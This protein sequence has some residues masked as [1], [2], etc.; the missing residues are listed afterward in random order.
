VSWAVEGT[1]LE[2][3]NCDAICPCRRIDGVFGG[4]STHGICVGALSWGIERGTADGLELDD[5]S[6]ALVYRYDDDEPLSPWRLTLHV[7]ERAGRAE[8]EALAGIF[9]G[10]SGGGARVQGLPWIRKPATVLGVHASRIELE[11]RSERRFLRVADRVTLTI[12]GAVETEQ[13]VS[14]IVPGH[15]RLGTELC[16]D[17]LRLDDGAVQVEFRGNC[18]FTTGFAYRSDE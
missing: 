18:A 12:R 1:Y 2:S 13:T 16:A 14:C 6:V 17:E 4:R 10:R 8:Q 7:D 9:L 15:D 5:L 11:H 3:C